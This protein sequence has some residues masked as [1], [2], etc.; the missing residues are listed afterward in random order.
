MSSIEYLLECY[1]LGEVVENYELVKAIEAL[2]SA[3][4]TLKKKVTIAK[5]GVV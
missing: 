2:G 3:S 1:I 5:S 4:G